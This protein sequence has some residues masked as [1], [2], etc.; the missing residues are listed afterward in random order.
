[1]ENNQFENEKR[2]GTNYDLKSD[3]VET[4]ANADTDETPEYSQEELNR[5]RKTSKFHI[6]DAAKVLFIKAWF[7]GAVCYFFIWGLGLT[8]SLDILFIVGMAIGLVT[9]LLTN[10]VIR[11]LEK[12]PGGYDHWLMVTHKGM[13][14]FFLNLVYAFLIIYCVFG[15]YNIINALII[16]ITGAGDTVPLGVEPVFFGVFC[17][18]FDY[19]FVKLKHLV[20]GLF[21]KG[22]SAARKDG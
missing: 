17:M 12:T 5:Y 20:M 21:A 22:R 14:G 3:A 8:N 15:F 18:G 4:L 16:A 9:D 6:S 1:M 11:F 19:L 13:V 10:N 7:A 2:S